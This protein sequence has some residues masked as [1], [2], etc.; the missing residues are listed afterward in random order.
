MKSH[1]IRFFFVMTRGTPGSCFCCW[2]YGV[3]I[4]AHLRFPRRFFDVA[5][6]P[7]GHCA[8]A[9]GAVPPVAASA[10]AAVCSKPRRG[11]AGARKAAAEDG[12]SAGT[13]KQLGLAAR[14]SWEYHVF[15]TPVLFN[16]LYIF[17]GVG[18]WGMKLF[19]VCFNCL[20][21]VVK[22]VIDHSLC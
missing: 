14:I 16:A 3:L 13:A 18:A 6:A 5:N 20:L 21:Y 22:P 9:A 4:W 1:R 10:G 19:L 15:K 7:R 8:V 2:F 11:G 17:L 12:R